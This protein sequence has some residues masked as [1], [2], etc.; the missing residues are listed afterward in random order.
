MLRAVDLPTSAA[1][2][3]NRRTGPKTLRDVNDRPSDRRIIA[4]I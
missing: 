2:V 1:R 4:Y 3:D